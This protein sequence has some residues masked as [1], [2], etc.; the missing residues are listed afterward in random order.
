LAPN[1]AAWIVVRQIDNVE[2]VVAAERVVQGVELVTRRLPGGYEELPPR[3]RRPMMAR[4][5]R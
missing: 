5:A 2:Y 4:W 1:A 3:R